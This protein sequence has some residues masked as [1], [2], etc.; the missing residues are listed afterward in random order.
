MCQRLAFS[1][2]FAH[3]ISIEMKCKEVQNS[4]LNGGDRALRVITTIL[5]N[6]KMK[7][8]TSSV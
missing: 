6:F 3:F 4:L 2:F 8:Q 7:V 5:L 1:H